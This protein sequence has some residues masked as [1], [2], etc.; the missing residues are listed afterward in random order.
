MRKVFIIVLSVM[1][2][3]ASIAKIGE[4]NLT[5]AV[6][7]IFLLVVVLLYRRFRRSAAEV[8]WACQAAAAIAVTLGLGTVVS[9]VGHS[10]AVISVA[11]SEGEW[12]PLTSLRFT[13][14]AM[15][16][17]SGAMNMAVYRAIKAGRRWAV[18]VG[19]A[20]CLLF[21]LYLLLLL[22]LPGTG[23]TVRPM[24]GLWSA[25]F[26]WLGA[27]VLATK[28]RNGTQLGL[29]PQALPQSPLIEKPL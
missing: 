13:T 6:F 17:Y 14:G 16:L 20:T 8:P 12:T 2:F 1:V 28:G 19:A 4:R 18:G 22:P 10:V 25:Y 7:S 21:C 29:A 27:A 26:L 5:A 9:G 15:L 11:F 24:L 23:G 3:L